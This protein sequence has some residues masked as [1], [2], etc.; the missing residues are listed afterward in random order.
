MGEKDTP[1]EVR[2]TEAT[3]DYLEAKMRTAVADGIRAAMTEEDAQRF[4]SAGFTMLQKQAAQKTGLFVGVLV[5]SFFKK[6]GM[7][8]V[9]GSIVY[10]VGGWAGLAALFKAI[11]GGSGQ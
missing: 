7:F 3:V 4:W 11:F 1:D 6:V 10:A 9:L 2:L 5:L 8:L